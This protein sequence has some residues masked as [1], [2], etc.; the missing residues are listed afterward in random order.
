MLGEIT[1]QA[2]PLHDADEISKD[3]GKVIVIV[4]DGE[5]IGKEIELAT[6]IISL[7]V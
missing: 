3:K 7:L 2:I 5:L 1:V 4:P 6:E